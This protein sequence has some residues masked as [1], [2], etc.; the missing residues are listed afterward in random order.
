MNKFNK[1]KLIGIVAASLSAVSLMGVGFASWVISGEKE[2]NVGNITVEVG[3]VIDNRITI[4]DASVTDGGLNF[5]ASSTKTDGALL[6]VQ[7]GQEDLTFSVKYTI[8][9]HTD[10]NKFE[11]FAYIAEANQ[12]AFTTAT[13][14]KQLIQMP[15]TL[16]ITETGTPTN[17][18]SFNGTNLTLATG[19]ARE[20]NQTGY[21]TITVTQT[22]TF[23]WGKAF[24]NHNPSMVKLNDKIFN[25]TAGTDEASA[26][27]EILKD[28][29]TVLQGLKDSLNN[30]KVVLQP[31]IVTQ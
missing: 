24:G 13:T 10:T 16:N 31:R 21:G 29:I 27:V 7:N 1:G 8:N 28:N 20:A 14:T 3:N 25:S 30:F 6:D 9:N 19:V 26:T 4:T 17:S 12:A 2:A 5:D 22:F 18:V 11:V 15:N 23:T